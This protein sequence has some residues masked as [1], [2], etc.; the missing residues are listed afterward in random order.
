MNYYVNNNLFYKYSYRQS[1]FT[2]YDDEFIYDYANKTI[3]FKNTS[4]STNRFVNFYLHTNPVPKWFK[5]NEKFIIFIENLTNTK[6]NPIFIQVYVKNSENTETKIADT[7]NSSVNY[8]IFTI[9][10]DAVSILIRLNTNSVINEYNDINIYL[11][12]I[13][14]IP[15]TLYE[16]Q[17]Q[18]PKNVFKDL[19]HSPYAFSD[20]TETGFFSI[21]SSINIVDAPQAIN[22]SGGVLFNYKF[23]NNNDFKLQIAF[24]YGRYN[25]TFYIRTANMNNI[26]SKWKEF[27]DSS[28]LNILNSILNISKANYTLTSSYTKST[29][30]IDYTLDPDTNIITINGIQ[31]TSMSFYNIFEYPNTNYLKANTKYIIY[32]NLSEE[33]ENVYLELYSSDAASKVNETKIAKI[34]KTTA[35]ITPSDAIGFLFRVRIDG[36]NTTVSNA[37][38]KFDIYE[39]SDQIYNL[40]N[41]YSRNPHEYLIQNKKI[42]LF[43]DSIMS[44]TIKTPSSN[45]THLLAKYIQD[46]LGVQVVDHSIGSIG[47]ITHAYLSY[48][49]LELVKT[50]DLSDCT[51]FVCS[52]GDNDGSYPIGTYL[53][54]NEDYDDY[55]DS[56]SGATIMGNLYKLV[57]YL[58]ETYNNM[59]IIIVDKPNYIKTLPNCTWPMFRRQEGS[60][61]YTLNQEFKKFCNY[62]GCAYLSFDNIGFDPWL[63]EQIIEPDQVHWT[64]L[65][66]R[67]IALFMAG[68]LRKWT[69]N[70]NYTE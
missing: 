36:E 69:G 40:Y 9:P 1:S 54:T 38:L 10:N 32:Y 14:T 45:Q 41:T 66:Y 58:H 46:E 67:K 39:V 65:G 68:E 37:Q 23:Y 2:A 55:A 52:A 19:Y 34:N 43:G 25:D 4:G 7:N 59:T 29:S 24:P 27:K 5:P 8:S 13:N 53:D 35:I 28:Y 60:R 48:N 31:T 62:Y 21:S 63:M 49:I 42:A 20:I 70:G 44:A 51:Y 17:S 47:Y 6:S 12:K 61:I 26:F 57:V 22:T 18:I 11:Y 16:A 50:C 15:K 64:D 3:K 56:N 33:N 30:G